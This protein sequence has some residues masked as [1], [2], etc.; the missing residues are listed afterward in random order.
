MLD[1]NKIT[2]NIESVYVYRDR[3]EK[4]LLKKLVSVHTPKE[5]RTSMTYLTSLGSKI[6]DGVLKKADEIKI[7]AYDYRKKYSDSCL[8][9]FT[10]IKE[11]GP[12][13]MYMKDKDS[14]ADFYGKLL[15][16]Y[17]MSK[18]LV[19]KIK[20]VDPKLFYE[21]VSSMSENDIMEYAEFFDLFDDPNEFLLAIRKKKVKRFFKI[22][23]GYRH[24]IEKTN[25]I[26]MR[27]YNYPILS[28]ENY[29][30]NILYNSVITNT[31][32]FQVV[33]I[34]GVRMIDNSYINAV[35]NNSRKILDLFHGIEIYGKEA[36]DNIISCICLAGCYDK[37]LDAIENYCAR[38]G[39]EELAKLMNSEY[40][41]YYSYAMLAGN[42][43][44]ADYCRNN[45]LT[46]LGENYVPTDIF[47]IKAI[48]DRKNRFVETF[49]SL[50][51]ISRTKFLQ[52]YPD[53]EEVVAFT[54]I[55]GFSKKEL[56]II[57]NKGL[58]NTSADL[59]KFSRDVRKKLSFQELD[60][61]H[62]IVHKLNNIYLKIFKN[63]LSNIKPDH[64]CTRIRQ[65]I[66]VTDKNLDNDEAERLSDRLCKMDLYA[67]KERLFPYEITT[68]DTVLALY[69]PG[70]MSELEC[71][72]NE[73]DLHFLLT[74]KYI[75]DKMREEKNFTMKRAFE[76]CIESDEFQK[77]KKFM[78]L[79]DGFYSDNMQTI[80]DFVC[81]SGISICNKYI[82][83]SR[84][85][86]REIDTESFRLIVKA[87]LCGK[88]KD[89]RFWDND[90]SDECAKNISKEAERQW[91]TDMKRS[92]KIGKT[93][94]ECYEDT[95]FA[96]IM[97]MGVYPMET[98]MSYHGGCYNNCLLQYFDANKKVVYA[99]DSNGKIVGRAVMRF[100]K[101][102][103]KT[104]E[105]L[106]FV[107]VTEN[108]ASQK[109]P[110]ENG[111]KTA[112]FLE[113][114]YSHYQDDKRRDL[115]KAIIEFAKE[116]AR[117]CGVKLVVSNEYDLEDKQDLMVYIT[118]SRNNAQYLDSL[119]GYIT[120]EEGRY[121]NATASVFDLA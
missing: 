49:F 5:L 86:S 64:A 34:G 84:N 74:S 118:K 85:Y 120:M 52:R 113:L 92:E 11:F 16:F 105:K 87:A 26:S 80:K 65:L 107:D 37:T 75:T 116:K 18:S 29:I 66:Q 9:F 67:W 95:S 42:K 30:R 111:S 104:K 51:P 56:E 44:I 38:Y 8:G 19:S 4:D 62:M 10:D 121:V 110:K 82:N 78:N 119:G 88:L 46:D 36:L 112:I 98:C 21:T 55:N 93:T 79:P 94:F 60:T 61:I 106:K 53:Y 6:R 101:I 77:F 70:P 54:D 22:F 1:I 47:I 28:N 102:K 15:L 50:D 13:L 27:A 89:I 69:Y 45:D 43:K 97:N 81:E 83:G 76:I 14:H 2:D 24:K 109:A 114:M 72:K 59:I 17:E 39:Y 58:F 117:R 108:R 25:L 99:K 100:T 35:A 3:F 115:G 31:E 68:E 48:F 96:G 40:G 7:N 33:R 32:F 63:L 91:M 103:N 71:A 41:M 20:D 23:D 57:I 12:V 73:R 90:L